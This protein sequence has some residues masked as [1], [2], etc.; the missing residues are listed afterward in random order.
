MCKRKIEGDDK[1][2]EEE[3]PK[4]KSKKAYGVD[5]I[6]KLLKKVLKDSSNACV[7]ADLVDSMHAKINDEKITKKQI[8]KFIQKKSQI[9]LSADGKM[10]FIF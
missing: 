6:P 8:W 4:K 2:A 3:N 7:M 9:S 5:D 1:E 10:Q